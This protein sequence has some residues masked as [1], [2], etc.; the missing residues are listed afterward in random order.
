M[1]LRNKSRLEHSA[2]QTVM[3]ALIGLA[4]A[5]AF[6]FGIY[7][8]FGAAYRAFLDSD[9]FGSLG[10]GLWRNGTL[11]YYPGS[12]VTVVKGPI[13]PLFIAAILELT[14]GWWP[15]GPQL[16][17]C[18]LHGLT[19]L[20]AGWI[21]STLGGSRAGR[22]TSLLCAVHPFLIW[23]TSRIW[24]ESLTSFLF[25]AVVASCL[26]IGREPSGFRA[27]LVGGLLGLS[28]LAKA[29][30]LTLVLSVPLL[31]LISRDSKLRG[32]L[33]VAMIVFALTPI[34]I[35]SARNWRLTD[36]FIPVHANLGTNLVYGDIFAEHYFDAPFSYIG[37]RDFKPDVKPWGEELLL[38]VKRGKIEAA[39]G[40]AR[41][42]AEHDAE[43][44]RRSWD[45][46]VDDPLFLARKVVL[47][48]VM[49]WTL[50]ETP[51][52]SAV[53]SALQL[54]LLGLFLL[55]IVR[56][57]RRLGLRTLRGIPAI[58]VALYFVAH[59]PIFAFARLSVVLVPTLLAFTIAVLAGRST[60]REDSNVPSRD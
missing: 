9:Q 13:Y 36:R 40:L 12:E 15:S 27:I 23:Y 10:F 19:V 60:R 30:F 34:A 24:I 11:S 35:W 42:E 22:L 39:P 17:Q 52:K 7:P 2:G 5:L 32:R 31:L 48:A 56:E 51:A 44:A 20:L 54:P 43:E 47:N 57:H 29:S 38:A 1:E 37:L 33:A 58:L 50:G 21:G 41:R 14:G 6:T 16:A 45:R 3:P 59:L 18:V 8:R 28:A 25:T 26:A 55:A 53:I 4:L 49:F 46:L